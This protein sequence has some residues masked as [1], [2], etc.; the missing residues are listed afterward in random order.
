[1]QKTATTLYSATIRAAAAAFAPRA[2]AAASTAA[3]T[4]GAPSAAVSLQSAPLMA[5]AAAAHSPLLRSGG[6]AASRLRLRIRVNCAGVVQT[7]E[8]SSVRYF[9]AAAVRPNRHATTAAAST[10]PFQPEVYSH[11]GYVSVAGASDAASDA[12]LQESAREPVSA[13]SPSP[14]LASTSDVSGPLN[15]VFS[16]DHHEE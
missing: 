8:L 10:Q 13:S 15:A 9:H 5:S 1:M 16:K 3:A 6:A 12:A 7:S 11:Q 14:L 4:T 2:A